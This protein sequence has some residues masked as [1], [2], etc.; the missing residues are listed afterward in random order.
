M[1]SL[2]PSECKMMYVATDDCFCF[3]CGF[4]HGE[5]EICRFYL[6]V[7]GS[8]KLSSLVFSLTPIDR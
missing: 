6:A 1:M 7:F 2:K 5:L 3:N 4:L 8:I